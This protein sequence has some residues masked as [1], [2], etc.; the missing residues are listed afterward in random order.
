MLASIPAR[1]LAEWRAYAQISP[2]GS[3][4][5]DLQAGI[6]ASQLFNLHR[7]ERQEPRRP[8]DYLLTF[9]EK[10]PQSPDHMKAI[11][12]SQIK[13]AERAKQRKAG[14][15]NNSR[16]SGSQNHGERIAAKEGPG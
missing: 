1:L 11:V 16:K 5:G 15:G 12:E 9:G 6:V 4:R 8:S 3:V 2:F 7:G 10:E 13:V 14:R